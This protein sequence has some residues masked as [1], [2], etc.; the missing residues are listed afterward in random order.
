MLRLHGRWVRYFLGRTS[1]VALSAR[2]RQLTDSRSDTVDLQAAELRRI[3]RDLHDGAQSRLVAMGMTLSAAERLLERDPAAAR[4]LLTEARDSSAQALHELRDLVRGIHPPVLADRGLVDA[5]RARALEAPLPVQ[6]RAPCTGR[7]ASPVESAAYFAVS[8]L[9]TNVVKHAGAG[10]VTVTVEHTRGTLRITVEDDGR[11][12]AD[13]REGGGLAGI[14][15][16][17]AAFDGTLD[18]ESPAGGPSRMHIVIPCQPAN[19]TVGAPG[20]GITRTDRPSA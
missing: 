3:E 11:G 17:L 16:R 1:K 5:I 10:R 4:T 20:E 8:E 12:G 14:R 15:R 13:A 9:L 6:V 19:A 2:V 7:L 18:A